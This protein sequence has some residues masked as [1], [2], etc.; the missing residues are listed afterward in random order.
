MA[1]SNRKKKVTVVKFKF[2]GK[3]IMGIKENKSDERT[4]IQ[5]GLRKAQAILAAYD[6]IK[7]FVAEQTA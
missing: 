5:F 2:A 1:D 3:P 6:E 4:V 7:A